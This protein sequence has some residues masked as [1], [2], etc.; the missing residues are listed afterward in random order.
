MG[1][2]QTMSFLRLFYH[3]TFSSPFHLFPEVIFGF[4]DKVKSVGSAR[5][6]L[7]HT[8]Q[9]HH[10]STYSESDRATTLQWLEAEQLLSKAIEPYCSV[11]ELTHPASQW[12]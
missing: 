1:E 3:C 4:T 10:C 12:A 5:K 9:S 2:E 6:T 11:L 7:A 8:E